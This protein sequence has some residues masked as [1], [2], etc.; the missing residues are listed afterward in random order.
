MASIRCVVDECKNIDGEKGSLNKLQKYN[1][2]GKMI[3]TG[4]LKKLTWE[5]STPF[6]SAHHKPHEPRS[7]RVSALSVTTVITVGYALRI[8]SPRA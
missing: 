8:L 7:V 1:I 2:G 3:G 6:H 4:N 5:E